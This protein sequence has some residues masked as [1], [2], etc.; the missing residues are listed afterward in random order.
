MTKRMWIIF[1]KVFIVGTSFCLPAQAEGGGWICPRLNV[2]PIEKKIQEI[3]IEEA[4]YREESLS[5]VVGSLVDFSR[6]LDPDGIGVH[7]ILVIPPGTDRDDFLSEIPPLTLSLKKVTL[8]DALKL[9]TQLTGFTY[10]IDRNMV[11]IESK[12]IN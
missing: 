8:E 5:E 6:K 10:R 11:L 3:M 9:I 1:T 12:P 4:E 2:V 7:I